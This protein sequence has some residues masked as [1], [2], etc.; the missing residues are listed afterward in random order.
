MHR[1]TLNAYTPSG[2]WG[3]LFRD[4]L[5]TSS[6]VTDRS[7]LVSSGVMAVSALWYCFSKPWWGREARL[8]GATRLQRGVMKPCFLLGDLTLLVNTEPFPHPRPVW[9]ASQEFPL[10]LAGGVWWM[11]CFWSMSGFGP[12]ERGLSPPFPLPV[13]FDFLLY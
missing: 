11:C 1:V 2:M 12:I 10:G 7:G 4:I 6:F 3:M 5:E 13:V 8:G 9:Y